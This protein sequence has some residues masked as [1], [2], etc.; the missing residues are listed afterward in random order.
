MNKKSNRNNSKT[1]HDVIKIPNRKEKS[2]NRKFSMVSM[3]T[4]TQCAGIIALTIISSI[5]ASVYPVRLGD[6]LTAITNH[7]ITTIKDGIVPVLIFGLL[8]FSAEGLVIVRR[9]LLDCIIASH[10]A[11]LRKRSIEKMLK[12]PVAYL[13]GC[14]SGERNAQLNQGISG[15]SQLIKIF[16]NDVS[17]MVLTT[18]CTLAQVVMNAPWIFAVIMLVYLGVSILISTAQIRSQ[19]GIRE[20]II[21]Q[22]NAL[23]GKVCQ[24][25]S[26]VELIRCL[27]AETYE[28]DRLSP[29]INM[30][31]ATEKKHHIFMGSFDFIK[32]SFKIAFQIAILLV[33]VVMIA[34]NEMST[35]AVIPVCLLFQQMLK[36]LDDIYRFMD[37]TASSVI[38]AKVLKDMAT[39]NVDPIF[40][41]A[42][43]AKPHDTHDTD[44]VLR[45]VTIETPEK[46]KVI[47]HYDNLTI[48][49]KEIVALVGP[50]G[51]GKSSVIRSV[52]RYFPYTQ[53][54]I[55]L[56][57][58]DL[59]SYSQ[60]ELT[61]RL[62]CT[63]QKPIFFAGTIRENL[64]YGIRHKIEDGV[65]IDALKKS[66]FYDAIRKKVQG[67]AFTDDVNES[68][69]SYRIGEGGAGLSGG[70]SQRLSIA[71]AFLRKP[72]LFI[73]DESTS[74][75]DR[76][77][78]E[79]VMDNV[80]A[81]ARS[82]DAGIVY[83]SHDEYVTNRCTRKIEL[84]NDIR[85]AS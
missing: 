11:D 61:D 85:I 48:P 41:I 50:S 31:S 67:Q 27:N 36:P 69:L 58:E 59:A 52:N 17:A 38:K 15:V 49:G 65:L 45:D 84:Q 73:F 19:N 40:T 64:V 24:S 28:T 56:W 57:G 42:G 83:I 2:M 79:K 60:K 22:K 78:A 47:A 5:L 29:D 80:E 13:T 77:T 14:A 26:I 21:Y 1:I 10:E 6:L 55:M 32:Q 4:K 46:N 76:N 25:I 63:P 66:F 12:M 18:I 51:C 30:I 35:V 82:I 9:I 62:C 44:I 23:D 8:F 54:I 70:E 33:A 43:S 3:K 68:I 72:E 20:N 37:E 34:R 16:C 75:L 7:Q 74:N 81:Y 53:G 39:L 71:R